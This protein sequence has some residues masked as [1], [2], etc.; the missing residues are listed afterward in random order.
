M[1]EQLRGTYPE[2]LTR[3]GVD[4]I[5]DIHDETRCPIALVGNPEILRLI[6]KNDQH[7]SRI[8]IDRSVKLDKPSIERAAA[9]LLSQIIP[10][11]AKKLRTRAAKAASEPGHLRR[12]K[13]ILHNTREFLTISKNDPI[14]AF[15]TAESLMVRKEAA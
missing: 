3:A 11:H 14:A 2:R 15:E 4:C 5:M 6:Q 9:H 8:G 10:E 1:A 13:T 7:F 12:L